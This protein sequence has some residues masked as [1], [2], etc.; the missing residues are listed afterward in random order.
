LFGE[1]IFNKK[2]SQPVCQR[3]TNAKTGHSLKPAFASETISPANIF[4]RCP[5]N[6]RGL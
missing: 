2:V 5:E 6:G 1:E 4:R 3:G